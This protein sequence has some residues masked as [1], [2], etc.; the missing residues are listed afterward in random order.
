M[1]NA[2]FLLILCTPA[3]ATIAAEP[4]GLRDAI[5]KHEE[6][7]A[8]RSRRLY[9]SHI[10]PIDPASYKFEFA[11]V[12]LNGDDIPDAIVLFKGP[13][14]CGSGGCTLEIFRGNKEGFEFISG[15]TISREPI[16]ILAE[17][18]FGWH[19]FTVLVSAGGATTCNAL[20]RFSGQK[21]PLNP[22][23]A[24]CA[25]PAQLQSAMPVTMTQ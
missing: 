21:Y 11:L 2:L 14:N 17:K 22:S 18:R 9:G 19:S 13:E 3:A 25:T 15:S 20:M 12:D 4:P 1:R 10:P 16:K 6:L 24:P 8:E 5:A 7:S 23:V